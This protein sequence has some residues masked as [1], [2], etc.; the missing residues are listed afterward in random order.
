MDV[1]RHAQRRHQG[2]GSSLSPTNQNML[3]G[4]KPTVGAI[5][6]HGIIPITA[7]QDTTGPCSR[8]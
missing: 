5:S 6:P 4:I 2:V 7:D 3:V 8:R 1:R